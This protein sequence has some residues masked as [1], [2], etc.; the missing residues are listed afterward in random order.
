MHERIAHLYLRNLLQFRMLRLLCGYARHLQLA[1]GN[2]ALLLHTTK[3]RNTTYL[4]RYVSD[5]DNV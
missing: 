4:G 1:T 2:S 5:F 3:T